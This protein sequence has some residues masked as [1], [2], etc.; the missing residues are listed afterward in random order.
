[1]L[2]G[3][4]AGDGRLQD[5]AKGDFVDLDKGVEVHVGE[6]SHDELAVHTVRHAAVSRDGV[7]KVLNLE[8]TLETRSEE[9]AERSDER[10]KGGQGQGVQLHRRKR[11][12]EVGVRGEEEELR[13][14]VGA[15]EEDG[16]D[17]A[18][19]SSKDIGAKVLQVGL[20]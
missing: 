9:A 16:V 15:R 18:L 6:E 4:E 17:V 12:R 14:L 10:R 5:A 19:E 2:L 11:K 13:E 1:M 20:M 3:V 8:G 7:A